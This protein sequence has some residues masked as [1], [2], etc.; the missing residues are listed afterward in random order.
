MD[1]EQP[2]KKTSKTKRGIVTAAAVAAAAAAVTYGLKVGF[3]FNSTDTMA[4]ESVKE[5]R[6]TKGDDS[7]INIRKKTTTG[8]I[9]S[10]SV[11]FN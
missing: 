4:G 9:T 8:D 1:E 10:E 5:E 6:N 3:T 2:V 7:S 11:I